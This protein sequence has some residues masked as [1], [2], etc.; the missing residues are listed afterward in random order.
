VNGK[1]ED[2]GKHGSNGLYE[3][4]IQTERPVKEK[5]P[6]RELLHRQR[7]VEAAGAVRTATADHGRPICLEGVGQVVEPG[8]EHELN[9][10][11][12]TTGHEP[13]LEITGGDRSRL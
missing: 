1:I 6:G 10:L 12:V 9:E 8:P 11:G 2:P 4:R 13:G 5:I 3:M 7:Q